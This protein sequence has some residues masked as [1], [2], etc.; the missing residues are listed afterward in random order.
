MNVNSSRDF[1]S[2]NQELAS[3]C[4]VKILFSDNPSFIGLHIE[5]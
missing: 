2:M 4:L 1:L 3:R 5:C